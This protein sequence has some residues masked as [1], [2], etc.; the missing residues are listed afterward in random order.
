ME[1]YYRKCDNNLDRGLPSM[2]VDTFVYPYPVNVFV[3]GQLEIT[4]EYFC[5]LCGFN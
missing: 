5:E 1:D 3:I 2:Y 4:V